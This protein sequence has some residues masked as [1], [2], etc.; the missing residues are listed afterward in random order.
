MKTIVLKS[1]RPIASLCVAAVAILSTASA[2][3]AVTVAYQFYHE[4]AP[5]PAYPDVYFCSPPPATDLNAFGPI[6]QCNTPLI[7]FLV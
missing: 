1:F 2:S 3:K 7:R 5:N 4:N 6:S